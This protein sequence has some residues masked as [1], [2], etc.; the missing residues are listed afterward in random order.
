MGYDK[1]KQ[2]TEILKKYEIEL[3]RKKREEQQRANREEMMRKEEEQRQH[4]SMRPSRPDRDDNHNDM[5]KDWA[6]VRN[7]SPRRTN[8]D[9]D[10]YQREGP[11]DSWRPGNRM[12]RGPPPR[13]FGRDGPRD[14]GRDGPLRDRD[15][16]RDEP[17]DSGPSWCD[18][19]KSASSRMDRDGPR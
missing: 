14:M 11:G 16:R 17:R 7:T 2:M 12:D 8:I 9:R 15:M 13:D 5:D 1:Q 19:G 4:I 6:S 18:S 10:A 3:D